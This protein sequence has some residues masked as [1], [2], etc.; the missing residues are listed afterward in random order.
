MD[1]SNTEQSN[2]FRSTKG[3]SLSGFESVGVSSVMEGR[4]GSI[5]RRLTSSGSETTLIRE[6]NFPR[7]KRGMDILIL[8]AALPLWGSL[9]L[10]TALWVGLTS[11]GPLFFRQVRMGQ[12]R[13]P[14][15]LLK[16]RSMI[17][18]AET[19]SHV[20]H[21]K[22]F[23]ERNAPMVKLDELNDAR[24]IWGGRVIRALGLDE[25]PQIFN[26]LSG[27][28]SLVG[29]RPCTPQEFSLF[30]NE[31]KARFDIPSGLTGYWQVKGKNFMT[32]QQMIDQDLKYAR[33][34]SPVLDL[35]ILL[36]T[37]P[38][39]VLQAIEVYMNS[40]N[41]TEKKNQWTGQ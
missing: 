25:L 32:F 12:G 11:R 31:Q 21:F 4:I 18:G 14:F 19:E 16:F 6:F 17:A 38:T 29:P 1:D 26:I 36:A 22:D 30:S 8:L 9:M 5:M 3:G 40:S 20:E 2:F 34:M 37:P 33:S 15:V 27:Q 41:G 10:F 24:L 13:R 7:W 39:V 28:M 35:A 23:T